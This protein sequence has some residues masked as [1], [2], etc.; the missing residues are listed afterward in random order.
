[1]GKGLYLTESIKVAFSVRNQCREDPE[2]LRQAEELVAGCIA[3]MKK[4]R[5]LSPVRRCVYLLMA[6]YARI[7]R[8][9][10][11]MKEKGAGSS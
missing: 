3:Q 7:Y 9:L 8:V 5:R 6:R 1:M 4:I 10:L 11:W 2:R